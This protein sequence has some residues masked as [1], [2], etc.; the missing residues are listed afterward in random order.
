MAE[1]QGY[2]GYKVIVV[3]DA[4]YVQG[5]KKNIKIIKLKS[6]LRKKMKQQMNGLKN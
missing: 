5:L 6:Y 2:T 4:Y 3:F 1:Y